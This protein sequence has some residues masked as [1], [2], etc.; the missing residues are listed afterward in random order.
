MSDESRIVRPAEHDEPADEVEGHSKLESKV[1]RPG[2]TDDGDEV[3]AHGRF[4][5]RSDG[6]TS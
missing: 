5:D 2:V 4:G 6:K 3:E 1:E